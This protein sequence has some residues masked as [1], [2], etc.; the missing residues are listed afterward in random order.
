MELCSRIVDKA[1]ETLGKLSPSVYLTRT[2]DVC[3]AIE[4]RRQGIIFQNSLPAEVRC[5]YP[6]EYAMGKYTLELIANE[7]TC[8]LGMMRRQTSLCIW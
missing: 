6:R 5:F 1:M 4:R 8:S 2:D 7:R 3:V